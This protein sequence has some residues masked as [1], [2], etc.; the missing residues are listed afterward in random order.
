MQA[1]GQ[2]EAMD[3]GAGGQASAAPACVANTWLKV[4]GPKPVAIRGLAPSASAA[5]PLSRSSQLL[6][7]REQDG[8]V[9]GG[10]S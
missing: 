6:I 5:G 4:P 2:A 3:P 9:V 7:R 8:P 1:L 10:Q